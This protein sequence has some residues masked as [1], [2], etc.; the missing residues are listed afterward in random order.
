MYQESDCLAH[1]RVP[2]YSAILELESVLLHTILSMIIVRTNWGWLAAL[3]AITACSDTA[4]L[5]NTDANTGVSD[6]N[7]VESGVQIGFVTSN[8]FPDSFDT[9]DYTINVKRAQFR[10]QNLRLIGDSAAGDERVSKALVDLDWKSATLLSVV[11]PDA[12][13]GIYSRVRGSLSYIAM[14]GDVAIPKDGDYTYTIDQSVSIPI[15]FD[16][17]FVLEAG[18]S[19]ELQVQVN[20]K[21]ISDAFWKGK[22]ELSGGVLEVEVDPSREEFTEAVADSFSIEDD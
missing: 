5:P 6:G 22:V 10:I 7:V 16:V 2:I 19:V 1:L 15:D 9:N 11:F 13:S 3:I 14:S 18:T 17:S 12:P 20:V 8:F 4:S 21:Q